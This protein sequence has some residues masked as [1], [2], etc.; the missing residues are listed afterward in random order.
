MYLLFI[1]GVGWR[2]TPYTLYYNYVYGFVVDLVSL[3]FSLII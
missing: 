1:Y 3:K 2:P